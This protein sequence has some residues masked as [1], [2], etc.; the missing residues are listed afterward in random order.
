MVK[1]NLDG[2]SD[3]EKL[4]KENEELKLKKIANKESVIAYINE[5]EKRASDN[6]TYKYKLENTNLKKRFKNANRFIDN[7]ILPMYKKDIETLKKIL[8]GDD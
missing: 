8:N 4:K 2:T 7:A 1:S 6:Q 5:L 3:Y